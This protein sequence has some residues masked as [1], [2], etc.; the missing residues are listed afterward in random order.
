MRLNLTPKAA[1]DAQWLDCRVFLI[2]LLVSYLLTTIAGLANSTMN[3]T[4]MTPS[5]AIV[6]RPI[7]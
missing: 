7:E 4:T 3:T 1:H 6:G 5:R 2:L